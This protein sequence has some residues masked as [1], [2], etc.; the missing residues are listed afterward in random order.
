[1]CLRRPTSDTKQDREKNDK[2][3]FVHD[4]LLLTNMRIILPLTPFCQA[5][6]LEPEC[7][8]Y[9]VPMDLPFDTKLE[10]EKLTEVREREEEDVARILSE[11]YGI[12]YVD[13][14]LK[15]IDNDALRIIPEEAARAAETGAFAKTAKTLSL[16]IQNPNNPTLMKLSSDLA[17]RGYQTHTFLVSKKSLDKAFSR[18][19]ELSFAIE[20]KPGVFT[21]PPE[22]LA[23]TASGSETLSTFTEKLNAAA[24]EKSLDRVSHLLEII[25]SGAF[26]FRASDIHF[27]PEEGKTLLRFRIDG[28]LFDASML[29]PATY[30][31]LNSRIKLLSGIKLN[32][33]NQAQ[34]GRFSVEKDKAQ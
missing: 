8:W 15:Q 25:L 26:A 32:V 12:P 33:T 13:L 5:S 3:R 27:E 11:K 7:E 34:D 28:V 19:R 4:P 14:A 24:A 17:E 16:A 23:K 29:D 9:Y 21:I 2:Q 1:M 30:H 10:E 20:S 18:Y 6:R 31:Q 22:T